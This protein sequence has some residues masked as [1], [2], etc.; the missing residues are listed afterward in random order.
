MF[1]IRDIGVWDQLKS[2]NLRWFEIIMRIS[3]K[4]GRCD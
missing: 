4:I 1:C 3:V 2:Y